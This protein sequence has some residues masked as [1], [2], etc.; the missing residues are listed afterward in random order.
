[1]SDASYMS[2]PYACSYSYGSK[3]GNMP[4][5]A[6]TT[7]EGSVHI[8]D[9]SKRQEW[10]VGAYSHS[11]LP[12][13]TN[14]E[15]H[16]DPQRSTFR[17][18]DNG[19]FDVRWSPNDKSLATTS[20]DKSVCISTLSESD[21]TPT[22][23]LVYHTSTVKCVAWDPRRDGDV[24]CSGGRDGMICVWDLRA[25]TTVDGNGLK[26][27]LKIPKAHDAGK[28]A[29]V[30]KGKVTAPPA[31]GVTSL[32]FSDLDQYNLISSG[33]YDG[34]AHIVS[35]MTESSLEW[36]IFLAF[37]GHGIYAIWTPKDARTVRKL[38]SKRFRHLCICRIMT[39]H[40]T[41]G[42]GE[43]VGSQA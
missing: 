3:R 25:G 38:P 32:L 40:C 29:A 31:R 35:S 24:L 19:V 1:M 20:A 33:T 23:Y 6:V 17:P 10:D 5:L 26:P 22:E 14:T 28:T 11:V 34:Y 36:F 41:E 16:I 2:P 27:V 43:H 13:G 42:L 37:F 4:L 7:E 9:T 15:C 8:L 18:H 39:Q 21:I 12:L 30:R